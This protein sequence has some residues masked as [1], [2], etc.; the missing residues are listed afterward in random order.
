[1]E[2]LLIETMEVIVTVGSLLL[3]R[4]QRSAILL[5]RGL[6][7]HLEHGDRSHLQDSN[8]PF[9][10]LLIPTFR[11]GIF[12]HCEK[13][14]DEAIHFLDRVVISLLAMTDT[15]CENS[16]APCTGVV[17]FLLIMKEKITLHD[18]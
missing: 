13:H 7:I 11:V 14:S 1:M 4:L 17:I 6:Q 3:F 10:F 18:I 9:Q 8:S 5:I 15:S 12:C 16:V 2:V